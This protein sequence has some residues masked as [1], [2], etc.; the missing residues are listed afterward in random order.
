MN[1][2]K[3]KFLLSLLKHCRDLFEE[4]ADALKAFSVCLLRYKS[5]HALKDQ[6]VIVCSESNSL[7]GMN[8]VRF[9]RKTFHESIRNLTSTLALNSCKFIRYRISHYLDHA[10]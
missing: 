6:K 9:H 5:H 4:R 2:E 10:L 1:K 7:W 3:G 8:E